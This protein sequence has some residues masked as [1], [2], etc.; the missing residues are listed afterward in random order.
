SARYNEYIVRYIA[1]I[2]P[3]RGSIAIQTNIAPG[4]KI[5][6]T[7]RDSDQMYSGVERL[8]AELASD[9][10]GKKPKLVFQFDCASRGRLMFA[11]EEKMRLVTRLQT[12]VDPTVPWIGFYSSGEIAPIGGTNCFHN[13]TVALSA[14]Y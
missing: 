5:T 2:D 13:F 10:N 6:M 11:E 12:A 8:G 9:L 1:H 4:T 3:E 7:R 14:L